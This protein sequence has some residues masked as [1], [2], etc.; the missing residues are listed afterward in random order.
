MCVHDDNCSHRSN[1]ESALSLALFLPFYLYLYIYIYVCMYLFLYMYRYVNIYIYIYIY[2]IYRRGCRGAPFSLG[3]MPH[4]ERHG[5]AVGAL[6]A[7]D[8]YVHRIVNISNTM[9]IGM[10]IGR[11]LPLLAPTIDFD[12]LLYIGCPHYIF[13]NEHKQHGIR[14]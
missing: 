14:I 2:I 1:T 3:K 5:A 7:M 11:Y 9:G 12:V 8:P 6:L 10:R 13:T 4:V